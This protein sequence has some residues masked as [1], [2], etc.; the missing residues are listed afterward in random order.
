VFLIPNSFL[1]MAYTSPT[2]IAIAPS[3]EWLMMI[4]INSETLRRKTKHVRAASPTGEG[5]RGAREFLRKS[6]PIHKS[7]ASL[8]PNL[9]Y[10]ESLTKSASHRLNDESQNRL[11]T[12][13]NFT[14]SSHSW[15]K[16]NFLTPDNYRVFIQLNSCREN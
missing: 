13:D 4:L 8:H 14:I 1:I 15:C 7:C 2:K 11:L 5:I 12:S 10:R 3:T 6:C 9:P 16:C